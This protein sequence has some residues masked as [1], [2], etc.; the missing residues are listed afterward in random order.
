MAYPSV[1]NIGVSPTF[2]KQERR[3]EVYLL[4][5]DMELYDKE[6]RIDVLQR[7]RGEKKFASPRELTAQMK[8]DVAQAR[9]ILRSEGL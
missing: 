5:T 8:K 7:L 4:D 1:T 2:G 9:G 6:L 3:V